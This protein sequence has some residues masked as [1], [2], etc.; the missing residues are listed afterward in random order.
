MEALLLL[1]HLTANRRTLIITCPE[2]RNYTVDER[3]ASVYFCLGGMLRRH[4]QL[5]QDCIC[6]HLE[7]NQC[8]QIIIAG[9]S[10]CNVVK[11]I[12]EDHANSISSPYMLEWKTDALLHKH[13]RKFLSKD[14]SD[15]M[16]MELNVLE[17]MQVLGD[18]HF[19]RSRLESGTLRISGIIIDETRLF[20]K[21]IFRN[22]IVYNDLISAN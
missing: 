20:V 18:F 13:G 1:K 2:C 6:H 15:L 9:H 17:Q 3:F 16:I 11:R 22:G 14:I 5:Q 10:G 8:S 7:V 19:V 12:R 4:D 21:E